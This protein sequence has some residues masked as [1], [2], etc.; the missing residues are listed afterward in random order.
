MDLSRFYIPARWD[1]KNATNREL[2]QA[3][4]EGLNP[5]ALREVVI[6]MEMRGMLSGK[7]TPGGGY[8]EATRNLNKPWNRIVNASHMGGVTRAEAMK[9]LG[10]R[11]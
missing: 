9:S 4:R 6:E 5:T 11:E 8:P 1:F 10:I 7:R 2:A 3:R